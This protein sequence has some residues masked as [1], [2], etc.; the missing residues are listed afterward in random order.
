M[1]DSFCLMNSNEPICRANSAELDRIDCF[2]LYSAQNRATFIFDGFS[3][4][5]KVNSTGTGNE[6]KCTFN[7][8]K[9][10]IYRITKFNMGKIGLR[11]FNFVTING[12]TPR[13]S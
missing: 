3:G 7:I 4:F 9:N 12:K 8:P 10:S 13:Q 11:P 5:S 2:R 1:L 6:L